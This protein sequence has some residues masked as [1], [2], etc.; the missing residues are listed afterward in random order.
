ML[1][2]L[3]HRPSQLIEIITNINNEVMMPAHIDNHENNKT[4]KNTKRAPNNRFIALID[5]SWKIIAPFW[6]L[7]NI[8]AVN[9]LQGLEDL[10]I[11]QAFSKSCT[12][13]Q[14]T[15]IPSDMTNVNRETIKWLKEFFDEGQATIPMPLKDAGL[16]RA[17]RELFIYDKRLHRKDR[18]TITWLR[19]LPDSAEQVVEKC[20]SLLQI[21]DE[22]H[23]EFLQILLT[24]LPG[25]AG[26]I[27]YLT[28]QESKE[29][30]QRVTSTDYLAMRLLITCILWPNAKQ[31]LTFH[32]NIE[33]SQKEKNLFLSI[34][35]SEKNYRTELIEKLSSQKMHSSSEYSAQLVFCIDVR[36]EPFRHSLESVGSYE[37]FGFAGFF[38]VP[39]QI[40]DPI[41]KTSYASCPVLISPKHEVMHSCYRSNENMQKDLK[42]YS[43]FAAIKKLYQSLKYN[44]VSPFV[45]VECLGVLSGLWM[46]MKTF[47]PNVAAKLKDS[48]FRF[49]RYPSIFT[50][51]IN[52]INFEDQCTYAESALKMIGLTSNFASVV[53]FCGHGSSTENNAFASSLDCGA[54]GGRHG[55]I[56]ASI[57]AD[58][59]NR[60]D[61]REYLIKKGINIPETTLFIGAKHNTTTD[62]VTLYHSEESA[63]ISKLKRDLK[64]A[65]EIN[66]NVRYKS[67]D[68]SLFSRRHVYTRS[69]D[70]AQ[71]RPE[72]G[73]ARNAAFIVGPRDL[74]KRFDLEGR[75][76]LHSYDYQ[77]DADGALLTTILTAPMIVAQWINSQ[78]FFSTYDNTSY[79]AGS[80]ITKN[81]IGKFGVMQGNA[82]D[83]MSGLPLQ[84]VYQSDKKPYHEMQRL[85]VIVYASTEK[86]NP[87]VEKNKILQKL[88]GNGWVHL[89]CIDPKSHKTLLLQRDFSWK[90]AKD[91]SVS[92]G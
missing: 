29:L 23:L 28:E 19:S 75:C 55:G 71:V 1:A 58:I 53:V 3:I 27:K 5:E 70:W 88:F 63:V 40:T 9:P 44:F 2:S 49:L 87:I 61:V 76:F 10:P 82:S 6:P 90:E 42:N 25:W 81:V 86:V 43:R 64:R 12:H 31:L 78:Y 38:G 77:I 36:S 46:G 65:Q 54:C 57:L 4:D 66:S 18:N 21:P 80:K 14:K 50:P 79:G 51:D 41:S 16:Y 20:L 73:L 35:Q 74:T 83:L 47:F 69:Q 92:V 13:F 37:T 26:Y 67:M 24:S 39:V 62:A 56:N 60:I 89:V 7:K 91:S 84:S 22:K 59:L 45:L 32:E 48:I 72:W 68:K 17:C 33:K 15:D 30:S 34:E 8:I 52:S 11:E 85:L